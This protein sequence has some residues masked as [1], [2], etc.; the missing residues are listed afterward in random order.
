MTR[1]LDVGLFDLV[2]STGLFDYLQQPVARRLVTNLFQLLNPGGR[3]LVA[4]FLPGIRDV[5]Y[6][7]AFMDWRLVYRDED[8]LNALFT[9]ED[10]ANHEFFMGAN[11]NI[12][13]V[14]VR[15]A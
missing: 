10:L 5:G 6:M 12:A 8:A 4:N 15:K 2:Y 11:R 1:H 7:E 13:Y 9:R 3:L 14:V